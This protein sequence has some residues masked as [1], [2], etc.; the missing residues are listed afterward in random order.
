MNRANRIA[1]FKAFSE[2]LGQPQDPRC[3]LVAH[4]KIADEHFDA[5]RAATRD[6]LVACV[7]DPEGAETDEG[8]LRQLSTNLDQLYNM[9]PNGL[10]LPKV[11]FEN[12]YNALHKAMA[13]WVKSWN[14]DHLIHQLFSQ[15]RVRVVQG[16]ST[17]AKDGRPYSSTKMHSDL[18]AGDVAD[19]VN[20]LVPIM[21]DLAATTVEYYQPPEGFEDRFIR[22]LDDYDEGKEFEGKVSQYPLA[23]AFGYTTLHDATVL[24]KT[25]RKGGDVRVNLQ[26][27]IRRPLSDAD[28][29]A[30]ESACM[31]ERLAVYIDPEA[32]YPLG[33]S[34]FMH[35]HQSNEDAKR[36]I[37]TKEPTW[38]VVDSL[39]A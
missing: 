10:L 7:P 30:M 6:Y 19:S 34:K 22:V 32:W 4:Y 26:F 23:P 12:E 18:W 21:G 36:G 20:F 38:D 2:A 1:W 15:I 37:F 35:F 28:R 3:D 16:A 39:P 13:D 9:T 8:L 33:D 24:H 27:T 5:I 29:V 14:A 25:V 17:T 31:P 11:E